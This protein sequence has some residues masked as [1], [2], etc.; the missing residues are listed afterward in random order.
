MALLRVELGRRSLVKRHCPSGT[1]L[2]KMMDRKPNDKRS[3]S[4]N[5]TS[6]AHKAMLDNK[7]VQIQQSADASKGSVQ[8]SGEESGRGKPAAP[9][10]AK[11]ASK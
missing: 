4:K 7:S 6:D 2:E 10:P 3:D 11:S 8:N 1:L 5:P 9:P